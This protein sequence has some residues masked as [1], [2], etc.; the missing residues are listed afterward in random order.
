MSLK[1]ERFW[2][3]EG[4]V[5]IAIS[6]GR[7]SDVRPYSTT[8]TRSDSRSSSWRYAESCV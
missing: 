6:I 5:T 1:R 4:D 3:F 8:E 7:P 2:W